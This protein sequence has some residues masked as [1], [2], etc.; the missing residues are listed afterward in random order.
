MQYHDAYIAPFF[1][2]NM[3]LNVR[4][5]MLCTPLLDENG[6]VLGVL[7]MCTNAPIPAKTV[8]RVGE[9]CSQVGVMLQLVSQIGVLKEAKLGESKALQD[10]LLEML[11]EKRAQDYEETK[12]IAAEKKKKT[13]KKKKAAKPGTTT[14]DAPPEQREPAGPSVMVTVLGAHDLRNADGL[15]GKSD[16]FVELTWSGDTV[17]K[18]AV[19]KGTLNPT[20][21]GETFTLPVEQLVT[22]ARTE[23]GYLDQQIFLDARVYD[24]DRVG[25]STLLGSTTVPFCA[26]IGHS[27]S[28]ASIECVLGEVKGKNAG[29]S[30]LVLRFSRKERVTARAVSRRVFDLLDATEAGVLPAEDIVDQLDSDSRRRTNRK[31]GEAIRSCWLLHVLQQPR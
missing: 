17:G 30:K 26:A 5:P 7:Q 4:Y 23:L 11:L 6:E 24:W 27:D 25:A 16:P 28:Q 1:N 29:K 14:E 20:W 2:G 19:A 9:F 15:F 18:T 12:Q 8:G 13:K 10:G 22:D 21:E 31:Y 3:D